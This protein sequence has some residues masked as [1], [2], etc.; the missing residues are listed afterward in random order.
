MF[1]RIAVA[2]FILWI[3]LERLQ[4]QDAQQLSPLTDSSGQSTPPSLL[5]EDEA[6]NCSP[7][8]TPPVQQQEQQQQLE[9]AAPAAGAGGAGEEGLVGAMEVDPPVQEEEDEWD[10]AVRWLGALGVME[11]PTEEED[12][13]GDGESEGDGS[14]AKTGG[15]SSDGG[16]VGEEALCAA[17]GTVAVDLFQLDVRARSFI[18]CAG[19]F[20]G[21]DFIP[22]AR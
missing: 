19:S 15:D 22:Q 2:L 12:D 10:A 17:L 8:P 20:L 11:L 13:G 18:E 4:V 21:R 5:G 1:A 7:S 3:L 6:G 9:A 16:R 14:S